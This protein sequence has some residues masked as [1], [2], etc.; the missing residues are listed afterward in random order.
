LAGG[1]LA[2]ACLSLGTYAYFRYA[3]ER[4]LREA[5][6]LVDAADLGWRLEDLEA[7][8]ADIPDAENAAVCVLA[9]RARMPQGP[10][11]YDLLEEAL[12]DH[13]TETQLT[14]EQVQLLRQTLGPLQPAL[15]EAHKLVGYST[16][17]FAIRYAPGGSAT[18]LPHVDALAS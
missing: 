3:A 11:K 9:A 8:R 12:R 18:L 6:A 17:R 14:D 15:T 13:K 10:P 1:V 4:R 2:L 7:A 16:G 5:I